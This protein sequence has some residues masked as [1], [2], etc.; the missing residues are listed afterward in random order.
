MYSKKDI[1]KIEELGAFP[2][3]TPRIRCTGNACACIKAKFAYNEH[4]DS[5][6]LRIKSTCEEDVE[7]EVKWINAWHHSFLQTVTIWPQEEESLKVR[8]GYG[9]DRIKTK[10]L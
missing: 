5:Y 4:S 7:V 10:K 2:G 9:C 6:Y 3:I 1:E 8:Q